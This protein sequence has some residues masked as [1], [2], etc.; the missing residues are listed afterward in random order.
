MD[1]K[2]KDFLRKVSNRNKTEKRQNAEA[3]PASASKERKSLPP[4]PKRPLSFQLPE[5]THPQAEQNLGTSSSPVNLNSEPLKP[6]LEQ[7]RKSLAQSHEHPPEREPIAQSYEHPPEPESLKVEREP[8]HT[9]TDPEP[10]LPPQQGMS[11]LLNAVVKARTGS[12]AKKADTK[13]SARRVPGSTNND[14]SHG[15]AESVAHDYAAYQPILHSSSAPREPQRTTPGGDAGLMTAASHKRHNEDIVKRNIHAGDIE[16]TKSPNAARQS[17]DSTGTN[18]IRGGSIR[19]SLTSSTQPISSVETSP[20]AKSHY[21]ARNN[22]PNRIARDEPHYGTQ[23]AEQDNYSSEKDV[24]R[25]SNGKLPD[26]RA[27]IVDGANDDRKPDQPDER[28]ASDI[29]EQLHAKGVNID[30]SVDVDRTT[31]VAPGTFKLR[32]DGCLCTDLN[33]SCH[34]R[35]C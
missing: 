1:R 28:M 18:S 11:N 14:H 9:K 12:R 32:I 15:P 13:D 23:K 33:C 24:S 21:S 5:P 4:R 25:R 16:N 20:S 22:G 30:N 2:L 27:A 31:T 26:L 17:V 3:T 34:A 6:S 7:K 10:P 29:K 19:H 8:A 35:G